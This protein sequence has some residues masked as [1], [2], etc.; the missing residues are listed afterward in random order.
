MVRIKTETAH[1][2]PTFPAQDG[3][4]KMEQGNRERDPVVTEL[5]TA[6]PADV[7]SLTNPTV[8]QWA[9]GKELRRLYEASGM[10]FEKLAAAVGVTKSTARRWI[11]G[12]KSLS[13]RDVRDLCGA[14]GATDPVTARLL[15]LSQAAKGRG[16]VQRRPWA[17]LYKLDLFAALESAATHI[18]TYE[19][20]LIPGILQTPEYAALVIGDTIEDAETVAEQVK[21][22]EKRQETLTKPEPAQ[23]HAV[24][25]E[26]ALRCGPPAV[27]CGQLERLVEVGQLPNITLQVLP[28]DQGPLA[29][30]ST[31]SFI[32]LALGDPIGNLAYQE[33]PD[34]ASYLEGDRET[35]QYLQVFRHHA[36]RALGPS[37]SAA[38]ICAVLAE[39]GTACERRS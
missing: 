31:G 33:S 27:L 34:R 28:F 12:E 21:L 9:L 15:D 7:G 17:E 5:D 4:A 14:F 39:M 30:G 13:W 18:W 38:M 6:T 23:L 26:A 19:T 1:S 29:T 10:T 25:S 20:S 22:R 8:A 3:R 32:V 2:D 24:L 37:E 35:A 11:M 36:D 16:I